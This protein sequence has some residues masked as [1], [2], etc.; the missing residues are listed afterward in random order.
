VAVNCAAIPENLLEATMFGYEKGAFTGAHK[1]TIGKFEE[2]Q[3]GTLLLDE[4]SEM[5]LGLQAK[6]L[7]V[8]QENQ[9]EKIGGNKSIDLNVR[10]LATTNRDLLSEVKNGRFREDL[11]YRL[12]VFPITTV[13]LRDR[14]GDIFPLAK[15][16]V[17]NVCERN[18][19]CVPSLS[20][21]A[22]S[23]LEAHQ[24]PGNVRELANVIERSLIICEGDVLVSSDIILDEVDAS[25][26]RDTKG[27]DGLVEDMRTHETSRIIDVLREENGRR[28]EAALRLGI[29]P[30]TLRYKLAKMREMGIVVPRAAA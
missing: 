25:C 13:P 9:L 30:R 22:R 2:A 11:Y 10:I 12:N 17:K 19:R 21:E 29:S 24:W 28:R 7:R 5:D 1:T 20:L 18:S 4:I 3:N 8:L 15:H 27:S 26:D 6:L 16:V 23:T 14:P